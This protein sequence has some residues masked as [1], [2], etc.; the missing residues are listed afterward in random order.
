MPASCCI[1]LSAKQQQ[2]LITLVWQVLHSAV[3]TGALVLPVAPDS[4]QL[5]KLAASFV[6][7]YVDEKLRGC[8]GTCHAS[9]PL[10]QDV[11]QHSYSSAFEDW[12][13]NPLTEAE[14][15]RLS[16]DISILSTLQPMANL[17]E[18]ALLDELEVGVDGLVIA[19][20]AQRAV[21]LPSVW[22]SLTSAKAFVQALKQKAGWPKNYWQTGIELWRFTTQV[23]YSRSAQDLAE[24]EHNE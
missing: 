10:W 24:L 18:P 13:F 6:T 12:R 19:Q 17:G 1:K 3:K 23:V 8:I 14:L 9:I 7:L 11:C 15:T 21:F 20:G 5:N 2:L 16:F 22:R 4:A